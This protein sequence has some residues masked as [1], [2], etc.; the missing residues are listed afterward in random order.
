M[1]EPKP[2]RII[3]DDS[4]AQKAELKELRAQIDSEKP[5]LRFS[6]PSV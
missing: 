5:A 2:N 4:P 3:R 1:V 6:E